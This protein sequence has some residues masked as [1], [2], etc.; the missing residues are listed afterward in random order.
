MNTTGDARGGTTSCPGWTTALASPIC[1]GGQSAGCRAEFFEFIDRG[2]EDEVLLRLNREALDALRIVPRLPVDVSHRST[3]TTLFSRPIAM[4]LAIAPTAAAGLVWHE[5]ELALARAAARAG[6]PFT[7]ATGA[8][9]S[10]ERIAAEAGGRLWFQLYVWRDA[11]LSFRLIERVERAGY[12]ALIVTVDTPVSANR[13]YNRRNGFGVPFTPSVRSVLDILTHPRWFAG[14]IGRYLATTGIPQYE[15]HPPAHR[16]RIT[17]APA[18]PA[19][20]HDDAFDWAGFARIRAAWPRTL[21][22]KGILHPDDARAAVR[23]GADAVIVSNHGGRNLDA[24]IPAIDALPGIVAA[25]GGQAAVLLDS[26]VRRGSD[27]VRAVALGAQAVLAG[28]APLYGTAVAGEA[29]AAKA[30]SILR[31]ELDTTMA[32]AGCPT[33]ADISSRTLA[34]RGAGGRG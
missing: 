6:V 18:A 3:G 7:S 30:L 24:A 23:H 15:N 32:M 1:A 5:G 27:I 16:L 29:G 10:L 31:H 11:T 34:P 19:V 8:L 22:I 26:G 12:E 25:V 20:L 17:G 13:G 4:P 33:I 21:M 14:T 2:T 28:R 9:T